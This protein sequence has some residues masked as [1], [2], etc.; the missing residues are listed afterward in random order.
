MVYGS[1]V[2]TGGTML[3]EPTSGFRADG[4]ARHIRDGY[5]MERAT[6]IEAD[7]TASLTDT[8]V[9]EAMLAV[10]AEADDNPL[11]FRQ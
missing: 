7:V 11:F 1:L 3:Q 8:G 10:E 5:G 4:N 2:I 6:R 9:P